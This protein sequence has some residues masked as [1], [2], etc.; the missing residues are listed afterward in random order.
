MIQGYCVCNTPN[1]FLRK[2]SLVLA[3][4]V[5]W[6]TEF[7]NKNKEEFCNGEISYEEFQ[8]RN[9]QLQRNDLLLQNLREEK[10]AEG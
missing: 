7:K 3:T 9:E 4:L 10:Y 1:Y 5:R 6:Q 8:E 2:V